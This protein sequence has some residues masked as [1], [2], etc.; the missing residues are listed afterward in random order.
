MA[1]A[2]GAGPD[3]PRPLE[4]ASAS[5]YGNFVEILEVARQAGLELGEFPG[6]SLIWRSPAASVGPHLG[7]IW[8][9]TFLACGR[10][11]AWQS[12]RELMRYGFQFISG[13]MGGALSS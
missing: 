5:L 3:D 8:A 13:V 11:S 2:A 9:V 12:A 4:L 1:G 7:Q 6:S 10:V